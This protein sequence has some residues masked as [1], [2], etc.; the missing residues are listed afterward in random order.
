[1]S[2][3]KNNFNEKNQ[4][5]HRKKQQKSTLH[6]VH[7]F[8]PQINSMYLTLAKHHTAQITIIHKA[9]E[10]LYTETLTLTWATNP[11]ITVTTNCGDCKFASDCERCGWWQCSERTERARRHP[12][13]GP[14]DLHRPHQQLGAYRKVRS[15][16]T[17]GEVTSR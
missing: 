15:N 16:G 14:T 17:S 11:S 9:A 2:Y 4:L 5:T 8:T 7:K 12:Q 10:P 1:M 13:R 6:T 3:Y